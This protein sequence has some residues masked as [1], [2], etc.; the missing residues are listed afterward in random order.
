MYPIKISRSPL[1]EGIAEAV[2][3]LTQAMN[4][5]TDQV[6]QSR[7]DRL[8]KKLIPFTADPGMRDCYRVIALDTDMINAFNT[9][10]TI[11]VTKATAKILNDDELSAV[12]SHELSHGDYGHALKNM[13]Y[14]VSVTGAHIKDLLGEEIK[15]FMTGEIDPLLKKVMDK[16]NMPPI[17]ATFSEKGVQIELEADA[18]GVKLLK[19][20]G[21]DKNLLKMALIKISG[22]ESEAEVPKEM[23]DQEGVR[24]YPSIYRRILAI[25]DAE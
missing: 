24:D 25:N 21:L 23:E 4:P 9:G 3:N 10:C 18:M 22:Y 11:Y 16:G 8:L 14:Y 7:L 19:R 1:P 2:D 13:G 12:L 15:W 6:F 20:A 17:L 5:T